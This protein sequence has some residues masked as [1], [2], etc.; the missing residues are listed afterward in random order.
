MSNKDHRLLKTYPYLE[1]S[2]IKAFLNQT[3]N[4]HIII[5]KYLIYVYMVTRNSCTIYIKG[6]NNTLQYIILF[7]F[8]V[9]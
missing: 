6:V 8:P 1:M 4:K 2:F 9:D 7:A 5:S 3:T